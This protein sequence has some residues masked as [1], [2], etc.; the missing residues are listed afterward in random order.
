MSEKKLIDFRR[1]IMWSHNLID[2]IK[3][4][5]NVDLVW[6]PTYQDEEPPF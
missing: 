1:D 6:K 4:M 3:E 5:H 2:F